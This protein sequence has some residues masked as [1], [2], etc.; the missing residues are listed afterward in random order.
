MGWLWRCRPL[1]SRRRSRQ[2]HHLP[3]PSRTDSCGSLFACWLVLSQMR[4]SHS[5]R[6]VSPSHCRDRL[7]KM[8]VAVKLNYNSILV[9]SSSTPSM[10]SEL[11]FLQWT[12]KALIELGF[13]RVQRFQDLVRWQ[14][15]HWVA[16]GHLVSAQATLVKSR[17]QLNLPKLLDFERFVGWV[18]GLARVGPLAAVELHCV[19]IHCVWC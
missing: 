17:T 1:T 3:N 5:Y 7:A 2:P 16:S 6:P 13:A 11:A 9:D 10:A 19:V 14:L 18:A 8:A 15:E 4:Q 12:W